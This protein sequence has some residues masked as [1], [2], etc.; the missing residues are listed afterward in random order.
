[1]TKIKVYNMEGKVVGEKEL[2]PKLF[3]VKID[4]GLVHFVSGA[5]ADNARVASAH[6]KTR[7]E[8][9][10]GGKKPWKQKGTGRAR[11]GSTRS[12]IWVGGGITFGP[13]PNRNFSKKVNK[14]T[15]LAVLAMALTDKAQNDGLIALDSLT[16]ADGKT[17]KMA[18]LMAKLPVKRNI[19]VVL[20]KSEPMVV[21][22]SRNLQKV[23]TVNVSDVSLLDLLKADSVVAPVATIEA[24]EAKFR[25]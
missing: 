18:A 13:R 10:G 4:E 7:G 3:N 15:K 11:Q 22:A 2:A 6:T 14:K 5:Q 9:R 17:K 19:L 21:R 20:P 25:K 12:P 1:M 24:W 23:Q 8:V 16:F